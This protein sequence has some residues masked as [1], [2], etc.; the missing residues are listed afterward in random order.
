M[1]AGG[2]FAAAPQA[3]PGFGT[4][5]LDPTSMVTQ[6]VLP[7]PGAARAEV[8]IAIPAS[9]SLVG[10]EWAFQAL[11]ARQNATPYLTGPAAVMVL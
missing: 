3:V 4:L 5:L 7:G 8:T 9:P 11:I 6:F 1:L 10:S 2:L